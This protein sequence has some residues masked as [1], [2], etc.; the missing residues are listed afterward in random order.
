MS[1][2]TILLVEDNEL[3]IAMAQ[4]VL[5]NSYKVVSVQRGAQALAYLQSGECDIILLDIYMPEMGG[6][7]TLEKIRQM[8]QCRSIPVIFLTGDSDPE[9]ETSCFQRGAVD[10]IAKPFVPAVMLSRVNRVLELE[11]LRRSLADRAERK[12][13][14]ASDLW[15]K[16]HHDAL[17]G[18][19]NRAYLEEVVNRLLACGTAGALLVIDIDNF[20]RL[21]DNFGHLAGDQTLRIVADILREEFSQEDILCRLGDDEFAVFVKG[22]VPRKELGDRVARIISQMHQMT[23]EYGT[24]GDATISVGIA[25][26]P[27]HG[28]VFNRLYSC[29][30]KALYYVKKNGKNAFH[31]YSDQFKEQ[32]GR[33]GKTVDLRYLQD[34]MNREDKGAGAYMVDFESFHHVYNFI[35]RF[36]DRSN[37]DVQTVLFTISGIESAELDAA[38]TEY[39]LELLEKAVYTS[40]RRSDVSTRYSSRQLIVILMDTNTANSS[41]VAERIIENFKKEYTN[42]KVR[43]DYGIARMDVR[44]GVTKREDWVVV[45]DDDIENLRTA[46]QI[47]G[48]AKIQAKYFQS[49][50]V[51]LE[52]LDGTRIPALILLDLHMPG[53]D[54]F[55]VLHKLRQKT[56]Y[57]KVPVIFLTANDD[58][59]TEKRGLDAGAVDFVRKPFVAEILLM[60]VRSTISLY[61]LQNE[62][63]RELKMK[64]DKLSHVYLEIVKAMS[65]A[66]DAKD[67]YTNGHSTRVAEYARLIAQRA[68]YSEE[69]QE[70]IYIMGLLH[71]MGKIGIPDAIIN[72]PGRL[73][74]AEFEVVKRH[75]AI[76]AQILQ[77]ISE[78]PELSVG[79]RWHHERYDGK[80]YPDGLSGQDIPETARMIAVADTYD[81]MT[82]DR[83][84]RKTLPQAAVR[85]E[86]ERCRGTQFDPRFADIMLQLIDEDKDYQLKGK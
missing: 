33:E 66:I 76:G 30:D 56:A 50:Q 4:N 31:F 37:R 74:E 78:F 39:V 27:E 29:A 84:Y 46:E 8:E 47:F 42:E 23:R 53:L 28:A 11:E 6:F 3:D 86:F 61:R 73:D 17:T 67:A 57:R 36:I 82:S 32:S 70:Q 62:M 48:E 7:E 49:G 25:Q 83:S 75:S 54:G 81:A 35:H 21:N 79:A 9:T 43:I 16:S 63:E 38:E 77:S 13:R 85:A 14:E 44:S 26:A 59:E 51:M 69:Q 68:G 64:T 1:M 12:S 41:K 15:D 34:L 71:D 60:R 80:G 2:K 72:K 58:P 40:L 65:M 18:L 24:E 5:R 55:A 20:K 22:V 45:V 10:F 19:W 52:H